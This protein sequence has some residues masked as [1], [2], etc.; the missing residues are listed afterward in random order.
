MPIL[1]PLRSGLQITYDTRDVQWHTWTCILGFPVMG[2]WPKN[3]D[4]TD[5]NSLDRSKSGQLL[6]TADDFGLVK[7]FNYPC[8]K[9]NA[10][11]RW[12]GGVCDKRRALKLPLAVCVCATAALVAGTGRVNTRSVVGERFSAR[13]SRGSDELCSYCFVPSAVFASMCAAR[14]P[15]NTARFE[16]RPDFNVVILSTIMLVH[17]P[18]NPLA[19][20]TCSQAVTRPQQPRDVRALQC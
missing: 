20:C 13:L 10:A 14:P 1:S 8:V 16:A 15:L 12:E 3:S 18:Y 17:Y 11:Y 7:L 19:V 9:D 4:G 2:I 6:V 5:V